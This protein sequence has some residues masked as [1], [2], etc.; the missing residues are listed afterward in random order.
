MNVD[1]AG[2]QS[3]PLGGSRSADA[4]ESQLLGHRLHQ[5]GLCDST[6]SLT[7][8]EEVSKP[9]KFTLLYTE[10]FSWGWTPVILSP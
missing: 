2:V 6:V 10:S 4:V 8:R 9:L 5:H 7:S 3:S 1:A